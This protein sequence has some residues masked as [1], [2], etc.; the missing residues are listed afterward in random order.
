MLVSIVVN[1]YNRADM[2]ST[3]LDSVW[4][5]TYRPIE[6]IVVDDGSKDNTFEVVKEWARQHPD[7]DDFTT[8]ARTYPNGK[9]CVARNRGLELAH[10]EYI[11][12]VDDD[13]WLYPFAIE[14]KIKAL[15]EDV[16]RVDLLV[17]QIDFFSNG[18]IIHQTHISVPPKDSNSVIYLLS[19]ECLMSP[20][21][22]FKTTMLRAIGA[23]TPGLVFADD[24]EITL[25]LAIAGGTFGVV[26]EA[27]SGYRIHS[28]TR[29]C[30]TI[31][32][33]L[34][35][36]FCPKL[37]LGLYKK[38]KDTQLDSLELRQAFADVLIRDSGDFIHIGNFAA[39]HA[40]QDASTQILE[41]KTDYSSKEIFSVPVSW[42]IQAWY[43]RIRQLFRH[44]LKG[45]KN[46]ICIH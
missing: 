34:P 28:Q 41:G 33:K 46:S 6:L 31:R 1:C 37:Y 7:S 5:Q 13:D 24:M 17:N 27:L 10:G 12:Y 4:N 42:R 18:Q 40:C 25:R 19:H 43:W 11:Q 22:M 21:L 32:E 23:W 15:Q 3:A 14:R 2:V 26:N 39:A 36:D 45:L 29:Q 30:T 20:V 8:I 38:A 44:Y 35:V 9:L 16:G